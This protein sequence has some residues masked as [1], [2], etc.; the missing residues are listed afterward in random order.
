[1]KEPLSP[2]P[3][4]KQSPVETDSQLSNP[5]LG[6][7]WIN[8]FLQHLASDR[9]ASIYTQR[10]YRH[11]LGEFHRWHREERHKLPCW[12]ALQRDDFR[13][14]LRFLGRGNKLSRAAVQLRF[15]ALRSFYKFL[16]RH[17]VVTGSPIKNVALP[18]LEKRLPKFLTAQQMLDLLKAPLK[19]F[20]TPRKKGPGRPI[21]ASGC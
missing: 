17:G 21:S 13:G 15:C 11:A 20:E 2:A 10:N 6:D 19:P 16:V 5:A 1:M 12:D 18:K 4:D 14:Y 3:E 8:K 9:G 7:E